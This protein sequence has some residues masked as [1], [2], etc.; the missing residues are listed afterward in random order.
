MIKEIPFK[1]VDP[2][3]KKPLN[4]NKNVLLGQETNYKVFSLAEGT[5]EL[6]NFNPEVSISRGA[7]KDDDSIQSL[8]KLRPTKQ[9]FRPNYKS[10]FFSSLLRSVPDPQVFVDVGCANCQVI[11]EISTNAVKIGIDISS[12]SMLGGTPNALDTDVSHLW[13]CDAEFLPIPESS[14]DVV[15]CN[16]L[17][18]HLL[19]PELIRDELF[20]ILKPGGYLIANVPNLVHLGNRISILFGS[21]VGI[22]L[23]QLL[24]F[25]NPRLPING[26][27]FPDQRKHL[28]WF[29]SLSLSRFVSSGGF[30]IVKSFGV[31]PIAS[32]LKINRLAKTTALLTGLLAKKL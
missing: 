17:F 6:I 28:R 22:E 9:S 19:K 16:D 2:H 3:T 29:T 26:P 32:R 14:V 5:K 30:T 24:S 21:G 18:E 15:L 27:R 13:I 8:E 10:I 1:L 31:G 12:N 20:R 11:S 7:Y 23:A 25:K 4:R